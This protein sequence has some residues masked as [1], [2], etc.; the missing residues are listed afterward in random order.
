[1]LF[2]VLH[3]TRDIKSNAKK[4]A[5]SCS[6]I[7]LECRLFENGKQPGMNGW[8][9]TSN[10][11]FPNFDALVSFCEEIFPNF[12]FKSNLG[13]GDKNRFILEFAK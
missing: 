11:N 5:D 9:N 13:L 3:H 8:T 1:M 6:R 4:V 12:K 7:F 2:S 10:W